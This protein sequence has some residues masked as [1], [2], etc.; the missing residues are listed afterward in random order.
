MGVVLLGGCTVASGAV[1]E[2]PRCEDGRFVVDDVARDCTSLALRCD[3]V[4]GC[5]GCAPGALRCGEHGPEVCADDAWTESGACAATEECAQGRCVDA[6]TLAESERSNVGCTFDAVSTPNS[7][8]GP[9]FDFGLVI[10]N[11]GDAPAD[12]RVTRGETVIA[13]VTVPA[14]SAQHVTLPFVT[15]IARELMGST[16]VPDGAYHVVSSRPIALYQYNPLEFRDDPSCVYTG[17]REDSACFSFTNDASLVLPTH[18][19]GTEH[20]VQVVAHP[21]PLDNSF[22]TIVAHATTHLSITPA[23]DLAA[24]R[25]V[26]VPAHLRGV[27][28]TM[29]IEAG[30]VLTLLS[31]SG[32]LDGTEIVADVPVLVFAGCD[33]TYVPAAFGAC[34]HIEELVPP[35]SSWGTT[36]VAAAPASVP[37]EPS[38]LRV[39]SAIDG[40]AITITGI[41][42]AITLDRGEVFETILT[43]DVV[44]DGQGPLLATQYLVGAE[45]F[46][47]GQGH[48]LGDPSMGLVP[49]VAQFRRAY[50]FAAPDT[51]TSNLAA[52]VA[53]AGAD[54]RL[55]GEP[56]TTWSPIEDSAFAVAR[57]PI[58]AGAHRLD[59][60][61][62]AGLTLYGLAPY[63][64]Y[65]L[66]GGLD[67][68]T[69][70]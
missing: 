34:D 25:D 18:A 8:L 47:R 12:V 53:P 4:L 69:L 14:G 55:D 56:I 48:A 54:V 29:T 32:S 31:R 50:R 66:P 24:S 65:L 19:L 61:T 6:C 15:E 41:T 38:L 57:V 13:G 23:A 64:S 10:G 37:N 22:V 30:D 1:H 68:E 2:A 11:A 42:H 21:G 16:L 28:F 49:F 62:G 44:I 20:L 58:A 26:T 5:V 35:V 70:R 43:R 40:N 27:P 36:A 52:I 39:M 59:A 3:P 51:Y 7:F 60:P 33:C 17:T 45:Y 9:A 63:T 67:V 46:D